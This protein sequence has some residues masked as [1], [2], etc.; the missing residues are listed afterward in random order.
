MTGVRAIK[1]A[2]ETM[3]EKL[4]VPIYTNNLLISGIL[5]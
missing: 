5:I 3:T 1:L 4:A 2:F